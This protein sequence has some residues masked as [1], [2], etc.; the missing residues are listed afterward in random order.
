MQKYFWIGLAILCL[1][2]QP[3]QALDQSY[4]ENQQPQLIAQTSRPSGSSSRNS[5]SRNTRPR[6]TSK[7]TITKPKN[8]ISNFNH[9]GVFVKVNE[10]FAN[11]QPLLADAQSPTSQP[12]SR[13]TSQPTSQ[14]SNVG[15][16]VAEL[17]LI[18]NSGVFALLE[19][20]DN[21]NQV[22]DIPLNKTFKVTGK[23]HNLG[24][25]I[26]IDEISPAS[27]NASINTGLYSRANGRT[28]RL[29]G[30]NVCWCTLQF[31][32]TDYTCDTGY[33]HHL[34]TPDGKIYHYLQNS[35]GM[36]L[37]KAMFTHQQEV[38][39]EALLFPGNYLAVTRAK[40][41]K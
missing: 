1:S 35:R 6:T 13:P 29:T 20:Q 28:V 34:H 22:R 27:S 36:K 15:F 7:P 25:L 38:K 33:L 24:K 30:D 17:A 32:Q 3:T 10:F 9:H 37:Y 4:F 19:T 31:S 40:I 2:N 18:T 26:K 12:T 11:A 39:V 14:P 16:D 8:Q 5:R 41:V 21:Q 23:L